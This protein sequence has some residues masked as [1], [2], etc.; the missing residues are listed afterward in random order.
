MR[1]EAGYC[2]RIHRKV[3]RNTTRSEKNL[4]PEIH[5]NKQMSTLT[6]HHPPAPNA[7]RNRISQPANQPIKPT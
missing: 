2:W 5:D 3:E 4:G 6:T 7:S 1:H